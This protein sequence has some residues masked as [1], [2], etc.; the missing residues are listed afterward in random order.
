MNKGKIM[1]KLLGQSST[2]EVSGT[3]SVDSP[4]PRPSASQKTV[5]SAGA[6]LTCLGR[7]PDGQ[8][9]VIAGPKVFK[10][11]KTEGSTITEELDLR[12]AISSYASAHDPSAASVEQLNIRAVRWSHAF[13]SS[14][15]V[16]AGG[17]GRITVYDLNRIGEGIEVGRTQEHARQVHKLAINPFK[18]NWLLSASQDGTIKAFDIRDPR[19][20]L[21][22]FK[23]NAD[24]VRDV[25]WSPIDGMEFACS[26]DAGIIQ[27]WDY[28][29]FHAPILKITAHTSAVFSISWHPDGNHLI[30]GGKDQQCHVWDISKTAERGQRPRYSIFTPAP[31]S[32]VCWR[33]ACW[34]ATGQGNRAAQVAVTYDDSSASRAQF[35]TVHIWDLAR[36]TMAFKEIEESSSAPTGILWSTRDLLWSVDK[37]GHFIQTDVAFSPKVIDRRSLSTFSFSPSGDALMVLEE[38]PG[39]RRPRPTINSPQA[40]PSFQPLPIAPSF[41]VSQSDSEEDVV[42]SFLGPRRRK[43]HR[44][45]HSGR[46]TQ[47]LSTT[48]PNPTGMVDNRVM[49][50]E[51]AVQIT[52]IYKPQQV[53]AI[54]HAPSTTNRAT[55]QYLSNCY[56]E[57]IAQIP[58]ETAKHVP[59]NTAIATAMEGFA[60]GAEKVRYYRLAQTWR[61]LAYTMDLL[62]VRRAESHRQSRLQNPSRKESAPRHLNNSTSEEQEPSE[63]TPRKNQKTAIQNEVTLHPTVRSIIADEIESTS[64]MATPLVRPV[65]DFPSQGT[66]K[67][68]NDGTVENDHLALP[69]SITATNSAPIAVPGSYESEQTSSS[70]E[71]YDFYGMESFKPIIDFVPPKKQPLRLDYTDQNSYAQ[72]MG[73]IRHD[74]GESF[75]MF[76]TSNDSQPKFLS[77]SDSSVK[78]DDGASLRDRVSN[79]EGSFSFKHGSINSHPSEESMERIPE[80]PSTTFASPPIISPLHTP[81]KPP[82]TS[83]VIDP[84]SEIN[85][86][87]DPN[88]LES[89]FLPWPEDDE[90]DFLITPLDPNILIPRTID[91]ETQTGP[92]NAAAMILLLRRLLSPN[93]IDPI[94]AEAII[95]QYH[96]RLTTMQLFHEAALLRNICVP[97]YSPVYAPSQERVSIGFFCTECN[98]PL[99]N[100]PLV[101]GS[102]WKCPRCRNPIAP[103]PVCMHRDDMLASSEG[104]E[105]WWYCG[106]CGHG[107]HVGCMREWHGS[108]AEG[109]GWSEGICAVVGCMHSCIGGKWREVLGEERQD[110]RIRELERAVRDNR[111]WE[112]GG[113]G[114]RGK[115]SQGVR[116]DAREV[117][118]SRA[119]E[120]VRVAL[121]FGGGGGGSNGQAGGTSSGHAVERRRSVKV[122]APGEEGKGDASN[123]EK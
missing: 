19:R 108:G 42:G 74:S 7:S 41:A 85:Y 87:D 46:L 49:S 117:G 119:V 24:A 88:L 71:G 15:I 8:R 31:V 72:R 101:P 34:S 107:G 39:V 60:R 28:R 65:V 58:I 40:S 54:G 56:L 75:Q 43:H 18:C 121:G 102:C 47:P 22:T 2:I 86:S 106:G 83:I 62:L 92:L 48:P 103:C 79:W 45:R 36:S 95:R 70:I 29:K 5:Y 104:P 17:N 32:N 51:D 20:S 98:K 93:T 50:L 9:A 38:R 100:D 6:P 118:Q 25:K 115:G 81:R 91:F 59:F 61:L 27:K 73:L 123:K 11:V 105:T 114:G 97:L 66:S 35:S 37:E 90:S 26:T 82:P 120:G 55:F 89:D 52:G 13:L 84:P 14:T 110:R 30:S 21:F 113:G 4:Q 69:P 80:E 57:G 94:Q 44:R 109:E 23:C 64:N 76:S 116:R 33:P 77:G 112:V 96:H 122:M 53:V 16:T 3:N 10:I 78:R 99:E 1:R 111:S 63:A 12:A 67:A 68:M